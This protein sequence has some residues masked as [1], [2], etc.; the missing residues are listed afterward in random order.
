MKEQGCVRLPSSVFAYLQTLSR[1]AALPVLMHLAKKGALGSWTPATKVALAE[2][3]AKSRNSVTEAIGVLLELDIIETREG[4]F[5]SEYLIPNPACEACSIACGKPQFQE[6]FSTVS[7]PIV[8]SDESPQVSDGDCS[9]LEQLLKE[10]AQFES[11]EHLENE[12]V[13]DGVCSNVEQQ[14]TLLGLKGIDLSFDLDL[15]EQEE[16]EPSRSRV[17]RVFRHWNEQGI[18]KHRGVTPDMEKRVN[19]RLKE[20]DALGLTPDESLQEALDAISNFAIVLLGDEYRWSYRWT[21]TEFFLRESGFHKFRN[22]AR[23]LDRER[24]TKPKSATRD[25]GTARGADAFKGL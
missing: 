1:T 21:L 9:L 15:R 16:R 25:F 2:E 3:L 10:G 6:Q 4:A 14:T 13:D 12:Q 23:P 5:G 7:A 19:Q 11:S 18:G 24:V 22:E 17:Q 20:L 8:E